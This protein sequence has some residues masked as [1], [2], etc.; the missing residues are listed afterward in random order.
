MDDHA[1]DGSVASV[2][3]AE[4]CNLIRSKNAGPFQ[5]TFD[6]MFRSVHN[7]HLARDSGVLTADLIAHLYGCPVEQV[8]VFDCPS[9]HAFKFTIPRP[10]TQGSF[11]DADLHGGQQYAPLMDVAIPAPS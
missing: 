11:G 2:P 6:V 1:N 9:I 5:L 10:R 3:L 7:Y 8:R 4:L